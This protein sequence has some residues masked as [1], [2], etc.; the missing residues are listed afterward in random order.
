MMKKLINL[1]AI[2]AA[3]ALVLAVVFVFLIINTPK[4]AT[5]S[6]IFKTLAPTDVSCVK[7]SNSFGSFEVSTEAEGYI[8][9][10][11]PA[12]LVDL[13]NFVAFMTQCGAIS[14]LK[15]VTSKPSDLS[16]YGLDE[17]VATASIIYT[18]NSELL[19]HIGNADLVSGNYYLQVDKEEDVYLLSASIAA[20]FLCDKKQYINHYVTPELADGNVLAAILDVKFSGGELKEPITIESVSAGDEETK[21][22]ALS[23]GAVTHLVRGRGVYELDQT[24]G[25][26]IL[27]SILGIKA[28]EVVGYGLSEEDIAAFGF[29]EPFMKVE[30]DFKN[31]EGILEHNILS[32]IKK[33]DNSFLAHLLGSSAVYEID[34]P[35]FVDIQYEKLMLRWFLSPLLLDLSGLTIATQT[36][37]LEFA[38]S[39]DENNNQQITLNGEDMD[40]NLFQS[41][42]R[43]VTS[44][45]ASD[46][47]YLSSTTADSEPLMTIIYHYI[48]TAKAED[49]MKLY[50]GTARRVYAEVNGVIE[51]DMKE[52]FYTYMLNACENMFLGKMIDENW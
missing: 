23:F 35:A 17:P 21:L 43:L 10:D 20:Y 45:S 2:I 13:D 44:A 46:G 18:D 4:K 25:A 26:Q 19:L 22:A 32:L 33:S 40:I 31:N 47:E 41:F 42:Y 8:L 34:R 27:G 14:A 28:Q 15:R 36:Q 24:Y 52:S 11:I 49:V 51:F 1:I 39:R 50:K 16:I 9:S 6:V 7:V 48:N 3:T 12:E 37:T 30:Y 5:E 29:A 38:I